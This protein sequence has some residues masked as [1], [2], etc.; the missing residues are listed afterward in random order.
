MTQQLSGLTSQ[1]N[2]VA[3][4]SKSTHSVIHRGMLAS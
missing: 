4:E 3:P 2:E 1:I